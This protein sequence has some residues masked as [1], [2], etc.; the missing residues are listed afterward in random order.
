MTK[1]LELKNVVKAFDGTLV[2]DNINLTIAPGEFVTLVGASGCGKSTLLRIL[3]G[4]ETADG[5]VVACNG[6]P[7]EGP[8][9]S[10]VMVFQDYSLFPW[11]TVMGNVLFSRK[12]AAN[13][14][15]NLAMERDAQ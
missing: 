3:A 1:G 5:G 4:L 9:V 8:D 15:D 14:H 2:L 13:I 10:R 12:L 7:I 6:R 11:L